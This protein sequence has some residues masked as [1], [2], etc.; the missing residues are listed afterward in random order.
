MECK[1]SSPCER[2]EAAGT[3]FLEEASLCVSKA[4]FRA[5][6]NTYHV[7][8]IEKTAFVGGTYGFQVQCVLYVSSDY[9]DCTRAEQ[10]ILPFC[11]EPS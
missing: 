2:K 3:A 11:R 10:S 6:Q 7:S 4:G 5:R 9:V 8:I 1:V